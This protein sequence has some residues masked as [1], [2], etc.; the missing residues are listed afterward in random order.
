MA[1]APAGC[2]SIR[3]KRRMNMEENIIQRIYYAV[4][5]LKPELTELTLKIH[6]NPEPGGK[7]RKAVL[8]QTAL[9]RKYGFEVTDKCSCTVRKQATENKR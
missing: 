3:P 8:W 9:L 6:D 2:L 7:E 5:S 4:E 1:Y